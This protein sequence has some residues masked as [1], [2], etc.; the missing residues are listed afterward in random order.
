MS[1]DKG[2]LEFAGVLQQNVRMSQEVESISCL[3]HAFRAHNLEI[4][5]RT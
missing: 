1:D 3:L 2:Q 5:R 4:F